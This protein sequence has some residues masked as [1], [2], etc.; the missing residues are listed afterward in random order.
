MTFR[1]DGEAPAVASDW[2]PL[3]TAFL[4]VIGFTYSDD[5]VELILD[6]AGG[7]LVGIGPWLVFGVDALLVALTAGVKWHSRNETDSRTFVRQLLAGKWGF[8]AALVVVAHVVLIA[9]AGPRARLSAAASVGVSLVAIVVFV[10][11]MTLLLISVLGEGN[12]RGAHTW[13]VPVVIGTVVA[14]LA[15][16]LWYPVI[17]VEHGC[18][19]DV[20]SW[21]FSDMSHIAPV[22]LLTLGLELNYVRRRTETLNAG[23]RVAPLLTVL[24]LGVGEILSFSMMVKADMPKCGLVAVWQEYI[25]FVFTTQA[26]T[27]GLATILALLIGGSTDTDMRLKAERS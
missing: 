9:T 25:A 7:G 26:L 3:A 23:Q 12:R 13:V 14:Q 15:S 18:A 2:L 4:L 24:M 19:G 20:A 8:A 11:A 16:A 1:P 21:Y 17:D 22:I 6:L 5:F 10:T 27:I